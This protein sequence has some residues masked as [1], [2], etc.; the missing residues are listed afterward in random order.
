MFYANQLGLSEVINKMSAFSELDQN[1]W[2]PAPLLKKLADE[3]GAFG[4]A[5][6]PEERSELLSFKNANMGGV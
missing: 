1:F 6:A 3:S 2:Q 5:P 4:D